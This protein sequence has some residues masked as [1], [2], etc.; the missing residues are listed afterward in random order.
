MQRIRD[1]A[2]R[3]AITYHRERR[4]KAT[5]QTELEHIDGVGPKRAQLLLSS[6]GS[7]RGVQE[8]TVEALAEQVGWS[9]AKRVH[10]W[11]HPDEDAAELNED[12]AELNEDAGNVHEDADTVDDEANI[13]DED[14]DGA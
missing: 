8:A 5:L 3:F 12:A 10:A 7:V 6:F 4:N 1:E 11:F 13:V 2:H 9:A 14:G